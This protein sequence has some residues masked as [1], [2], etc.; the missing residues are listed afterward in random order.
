MQTKISHQKHKFKECAHTNTDVIDSSNES[1]IFAVSFL[2]ESILMCFILTRNETTLNCHY[3]RN[4]QFC[5]V[6]SINFMW[7]FT[8]KEI[9]ETKAK[10]MQNKTSW[11][12][13]IHLF[14]KCC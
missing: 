12:F 1:K 8:S 2:L 4:A 14:A 5:I 10:R 3:F 9:E 13:F 6:Y 11:N 7:N